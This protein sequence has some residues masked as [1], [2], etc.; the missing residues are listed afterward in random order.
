MFAF[1][2]RKS[3]LAALLAAEVKK[4]ILEDHNI[5]ARVG[6]ALGCQ[7]YEV[8]NHPR[9]LEALKQ[10]EDLFASALNPGTAVT[11][12]TPIAEQTAVLHARHDVPLSDL[13]ETMARVQAIAPPGARTF[14][15]LQQPFCPDRDQAP[16]ALSERKKRSGRCAS[17]LQ[18]CRVSFVRF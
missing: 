7:D 10:V 12:M 13:F 11:S 1:G 5:M 9:F 4:A 16:G 2:S 6:K 18:R 17:R 15:R 14:F 3:K 8:K